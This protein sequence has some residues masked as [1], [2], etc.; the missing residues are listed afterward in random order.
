MSVYVLHDQERRTTISSENSI[1]QQ[2]N[3]YEILTYA[4]SAYRK[5]SANNKYDSKATLPCMSMT[6]SRYE[7][8]ALALAPL[9]E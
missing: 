6:Q 7:A 5:I 4:D 1:R 3:P 2:Y 9:N 8:M